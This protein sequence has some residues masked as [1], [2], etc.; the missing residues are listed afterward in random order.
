MIQEK[1]FL[2]SNRGEEKDLTLLDN[3]LI[4]LDDLFLVVVAGEFN[5]GKSAFINA[6]LGDAVL[7]TGVTPTTADV[8]ILRYGEEKQTSRTEKGQLV[9]NLPNRLLEDLSIVDTP[10][11]NAILR[12]HEELTTDFIPRSD[13]VLFVTSLDRPFTESE[14]KF[15]ESIRDWGKKIVIIINKTDI[16]ENSQDLDKVKAFVT[17]NAQ[18][19]L[20]VV[21]KIFAISAREALRV[22]RESGKSPAQFSEVEDYIFHTL[23]TKNRFQL[24]LLNPLGISDNLTQKYMEIN[25]A[26]RT[27]IQDDIQLI[28]DIQQQISL[29]REDMVRSYN[30]RYADID[31]SILEFEK[32]GLEFFDNTF[33]INRVMD[34]LNKE[35][36]KNEFNKNVVKNLSK[37]IDEKV[38]GSIEWLVEEDLKQW[39]IVTQKIS[40]RASKHQ[41]R[42]LS[43]PNSQQINLERQKIISNINR[44]AQRVVEEYDQEV[45]ASNIA[46]EA[47]MAVAASAAVEVGAI[48]LG[49]LI[50]LLATTA[51]ADLTG[52]LLAGLT[53]TLGFFILPAKKKQ[54]KNAFS[55][56]IASLREKLS[57]ALMNE[58]AHQIDIQIE[59]IQSTIQPYTRFIRA[60]DESISKAADTLKELSRNV[61]SYRNKINDL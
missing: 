32:R 41:D 45:E 40:Q 7:D 61:E 10:G 35:R 5:S 46:E 28:S 27:L 36:I 26:Q 23:D 9:V 30:F 58:F 37:D 24:K 2:V 1:K 54:T 57:K 16:A 6:L 3:Q 18:K 55:E 51:S 33:R 43:D 29:F 19:L 42:I 15:L 25:A 53:A 47:Q 34:L 60:E 22:K 52:I 31:N 12:E 11:T 13:L 48:G 21:P 4:Q 59:N 8:T 20:G 50:T 39:Q 14:R 44:Q 38:S 17:D 56:N 49:T